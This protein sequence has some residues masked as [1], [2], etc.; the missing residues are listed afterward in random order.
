MKNKEWSSRI[1][2]TLDI[3][4]VY[5]HNVVRDNHLLRGVYIFDPY[6]GSASLPDI[7]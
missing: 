3:I 5:V 2:I 1:Y 4:S 6:S 7:E